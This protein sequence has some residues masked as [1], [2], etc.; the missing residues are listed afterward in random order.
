MPKENSFQKAVAAANSGKRFPVMQLVRDNPDLAATLSKLVASHEPAQHDSQGNRT[1]HIANAAQLRETVQ[2]TAQ[3][4]TDAQTVTQILPDM[5]LA[6]QILVSSVLSPK[7]LMSTELT[8]QVTEGLFAPEVGAALIEEAYNYIER[9]YKI[10]SLLS[11]MLRDM[12]FDTG[13]FAAAVIPENSLDEVINSHRRIAAEALYDDFRADGTMRPRGL[14]GPAKLMTPKTERKGSGFVLEALQDHEFEEKA[15]DTRVTLE[16]LM[17]NRLQG[18]G[19][20]LKL[21]V[22]DNFNVL[23]LPHLNHKIR[24]SRIMSAVRVSS[25][26]RTFG[27][28]LEAYAAKDRQQSQDD[29]DLKKMSDQKLSGMLFKD[30]QFTYK[31]VTVLK[32]QEQLNR[33]SVGNPLVMHLPSESVLP[34][35][36]PGSPDQHVGYF[37]LL[38]ADGHPVRKSANSNYYDELGQRLTANG[39]FP[40]A[41]LT[42]V[43]GMMDGFDARSSAHLDFSARAYGQMVEQDLLS[44]LRNGVYGNGVSV[45]RREEVW[46]I[47]FARALAQQHTQLLFLPTELMTYFAFKYNDDG[48]GKSLMDDM[49]ILNSLRTMLVFSNVMAS[50]KNSIGRTTV[51]L[52]LDESDPNPAKTIEILQHEIVKNRNQFFPVGVNRP[53]EI[54]DYI[55]R[56]GFEFIFEGHPGLPDVNVEFGEKNSNYVAVDEK[57]EE[58]LRKRAIMGMGLSP[59]NVDAGFNA[60]FATSVV[61]NN[62][63]LSKRV[64]QMQEVFC[65]LLSDHLRK[66]MMNSEKLMDKFREIIGGN[67]DKL[68]GGMSEE[69]K[70]LFAEEED[71]GV[72]VEQFVA[73]FLA[74]FNA[75]LPQPNTVTLENQLTS[76]ETYTKALDATLDAYINDSFFTSDLVG[77]V[78]SHVSSLKALLRAYFIRQWM[79]ENGVMTELSALT[80]VDADGKPKLD[81]LEAQKGHI[82]TLQNSMKGL[83][84]KLKPR[85]DA[86]DKTLQ[87]KGVSEGS[88]TS[89]DSTTDD[90]SGSGTDDFGTGDTDFGGDAGGAGGDEGAAGSDTGAGTDSETNAETTTTPE[91]GSETPAEGDA[92]AAADTTKPQGE[93]ED[94]KKKADEAKKTEDDKKKDDKGS[95][96]VV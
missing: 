61:N 87:D 18:F 85:I 79:A 66:V 43:K 49:K 22:T 6:A 4:I 1:P 11:K 35:H 83:L 27:R 76:L 52:K 78:S 39:S 16:G 20:D 38:D 46:R 70:K 10:K 60:E 36:I 91:G 80:T 47:M 44:R 37:V 50:V 69:E 14:L 2:Q 59:E 30:R 86:T 94:A 74:N 9:D 23:K 25:T 73:E 96:N 75:S 77:E 88:I 82:E 13:S 31:P 21:T 12:L 5:E 57:L 71:K 55:Q 40:S 17:D 34:V 33:R 48:I 32:T 3:N 24:E 29:R 42:K 72:L 28:A 67:L 56:A 7:D 65:P 64:M 95:S 90:S 54:V 19:D 53:T 45:A 26:K 62:I 93:D 63:L 68:K 58:T 8:L 51:K 81:L 84:V 92:Q 41:M 89:S 15:I